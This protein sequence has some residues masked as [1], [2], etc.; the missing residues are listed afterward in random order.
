MTGLGLHDLLNPDDLARLLGITKKA[1]YQRRH[2]G[3]PLPPV[4]KVGRQLRWRP[5]DV[6]A[7]LSSQQEDHDT[8]DN[9]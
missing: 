9:G 5:A 8:N 3:D 6:E 1:I 2:R 4:T 7:W